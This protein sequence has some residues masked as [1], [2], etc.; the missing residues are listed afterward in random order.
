[1]YTREL[2]FQ[3]IP[4]MTM[5]PATI[6]TAFIQLSLTVET[7]SEKG[8]NFLPVPIAPIV[9]AVKNKF[10]LPKLTLKLYPVLF[11]FLH[12]FYPN[13]IINLRLSCTGSAQDSHLTHRR[14]RTSPVFINLT[15]DASISRTI[16]ILH[17]NITSIKQLLR[18]FACN[19]CVFPHNML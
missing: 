1:M 14:G 2:Y 10:P 8:A 4:I 18:A 16:L 5:H 7:V 17:Y 3:M 9:N 11:S 19:N 13:L 15:I 12:R 6:P